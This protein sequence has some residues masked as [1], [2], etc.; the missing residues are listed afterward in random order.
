MRASSNLQGGPGRDSARSL[1]R[2]WLE[3]SSLYR[4]A[5]VGSPMLLLSAE[6]R[7]S[8][9]QVLLQ[10]ADCLDQLLHI[11]ELKA[12]LRSAPVPVRVRGIYV[13]VASD[14][15]SF[16]RLQEQLQQRFH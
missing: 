7:S 16:P 4:T 10:R 2:E 13:R 8:A 1:C 5:E 6:H 14:Y 12:L 9:P 15:A 3:S 11:V